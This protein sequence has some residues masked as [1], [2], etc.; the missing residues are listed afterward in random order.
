MLLTNKV[1][2]P[3]SMIGDCLRI[4]FLR[5]ERVRAGSSTLPV[6]DW[7]RRAPQPSSVL[8][9]EQAEQSIREGLEHLHGKKHL[10]IQKKQAD[11]WNVAAWSVTL[12][13]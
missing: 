12:K 4:A 6:K 7:L 2:R 1:P 8:T 3:P 11:R 10:S 9:I 5:E 13:D